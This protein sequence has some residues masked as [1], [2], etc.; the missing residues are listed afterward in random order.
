MPHQKSLLIKKNSV[1][2]K[3]LVDLKKTSRNR[4]YTGNA[5]LALVYNQPRLALDGNVKRVFSRILNKH[6]KKLILKKLLREIKKNLFFSNRNSDFVE[7]MMEFGALMCKPKDPNCVACPISSI[8][9]FLNQI[10][11]LDLTDPIKSNKK[12]IIIFFVILIKKA[13]WFNK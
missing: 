13:N 2:P 10:K 6:E 3:N 9:K 4:D 7:A 8:C 11:I 12:S 5:L 1:L